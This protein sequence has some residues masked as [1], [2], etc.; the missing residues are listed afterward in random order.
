MI[1][2]LLM[3]IIHVYRRAISPYL[4]PRC[5]FIPSCS[6]YAIHA[7]QHH[8]LWRG[9]SMIV[10]RLLRCHPYEKLGGK[11][12]YDPVVFPKDDKK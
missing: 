10:R 12:G 2:H 9:V 3:G 1:R 6:Q 7:L 4:A 5:R 11:W 8:G